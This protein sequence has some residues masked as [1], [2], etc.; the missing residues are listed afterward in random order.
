M[1]SNS[2]TPEK[3]KGLRRQALES[4][5]TMSRKAK[6]R[7]E[8]ASISSSPLA[9]PGGSRPGSRAPSRSNSRPPSRVPSTAGSSDGD[10][11]S[12]EHVDLDHHSDPTHL[13]ENAFEELF[14][15]LEDRDFFKG[16]STHRLNTM[17]FYANSIT[18]NY[19]RSEELRGRIED[20]LPIC[21]RCLKDGSSGAL[22][23]YALRAIAA[24]VIIC[25]DD[26]GTLFNQLK[27]SVENCVRDPA[28]PVGQKAAIQ[29]LSTTTY[30]GGADYNET[31]SMMDML[32]DIVE[33]DGESIDALDQQEV[34]AAAI[35]E[36]AFLSTLIDTDVQ[37]FSR[38]LEAFGNQLESTSADVLEAAAQAIALI[39]EAA[40]SRKGPEDTIE[41]SMEEADDDT[42]VASSYRHENWVRDYQY[43]NDND[44]DILNKLKELS[45]S[46][47][48]H[49]KKDRRK[50][51]HALF[52]DVAHTSEHPWR[53]PHYST[54]MNP[55]NFAYYGHRL[56]QSGMTID[57][58]WKLHRYAHL[59]RI[60]QQGIEIH[61]EY[62]PAVRDALRN[63]LEAPSRFK[64]ANE[65]GSDLDDD[66]DDVPSQP[67]MDHPSDEEDDSDDE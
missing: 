54:A 22:T 1:A 45:K 34:V 8:A 64:Q 9:S 61:L 14:E 49:L 52:R 23:V 27:D 13:T 62:D 30:F 19:I 51:L 37:L 26:E 25:G 18:G 35:E 55:D 2:F 43:T 60:L 38:A 47:F 41:I 40:Y 65:H 48:R 42:K 4:G 5:K 39:Y 28:S 21:V 44:Q 12:D 32:L 24:T 3:G 29:A 46:N 15:K 53:G 31:V 36:W 33:S 6:A 67:H 57:R 20:L 10:D 7:L 58:W 63:Y 16:D 59:R 66:S 17:K 56:R 50:E 11:A